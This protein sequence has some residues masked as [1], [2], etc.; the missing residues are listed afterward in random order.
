MREA[1]QYLRKVD[2]QG[3]DYFIFL[4]FGLGYN[5]DALAERID[6]SSGRYFVIESD[7]GILKAALSA[8]DLGSFFAH[9]HIH[10]AWPAAGPELGRQWVEFFDPVHARGSVFLNHVPSLAINP[11][12]FKSAAQVIQSQTFQI[13][14]DINTLVS[15]A[16]VFLDN[17]VENLPLALASPGVSDYSR[18][19]P[20][21]PAIIVSAGPSLDRNIHEL[22]GC[23]E[24]TAIL[25]T[26]TALKPLLAAGVRPHFVLS[27]DPTYENYLHLKGA[28]P[29]NSIFVVEATGFP[30]VFREFQGRTITCNYENSSLH[31]LASL[32]GK[33]G[34]LRAWGSV[35]TMALDFALLLGCDPIIF[36]GQDLAHSEGRTYCSG[37]HWEEQFF[38]DISDPEQWRMRWESLGAGKTTVTMLDIFGKP[39][40]TTDKL[41]AYWNWF[42][43][44]IQAHK[45]VQFINATEGGILR[46]GVTVLSLKEALYRYCSINLGLS[47]KTEMLFEQASTRAP[48]SEAAAGVLSLIKRESRNIRNILALGKDICASKTHQTPGYLL[49]ELEAIKESVYANPHLAPLLDCF[50]QMGNI[51]F[52]RDQAKLKSHLSEAT[53]PDSIQKVYSE[54][55]DS[56]LQALE[57]VDSSLARIP[58]PAKPASR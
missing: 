42:N 22:R 28:R 41:A 15:K 51:A 11:D 21:V 5:L 20:G 55:F 47:Q 3:A 48:E 43:K 2:I 36:V 8:R 37:L 17:F 34:T 1:R 25:A 19:L 13:F 56:V 26:D 40:E 24:R 39:V 32:L 14:T 30:E 54:Y 53:D 29:G 58:L 50:N 49:H 16:K 57:S 9:P 4:G 33:K 7:P 27:G 10:F 44:E 31:S 18:R 23:E 46:E 12:L 38:S 52:L 45:D 35:A 6:I